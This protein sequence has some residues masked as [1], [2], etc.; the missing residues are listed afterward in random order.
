MEEYKVEYAE[1]TKKYFTITVKAQS[2]KEAIEKVRGPGVEIECS[3][4]HESSSRSE[5][6]A[7]PIHEGFFGWL[8]LLWPSKRRYVNE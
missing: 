3:E 5:W 4:E 7:T 8:S 2:R 1:V 6:T